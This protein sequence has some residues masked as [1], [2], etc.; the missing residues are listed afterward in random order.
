MK[1]HD[2]ARMAATCMVFMLHLQQAQQEACCSFRQR[3]A[4]DREH[5]NHVASRIVRSHRATEAYLAGV[6]SCAGIGTTAELPMLGAD[7]AGMGVCVQ[8][9]KSLG[10]LSSISTYDVV[11]RDAGTNLRPSRTLASNG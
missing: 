6:G 11:L 8:Q 10:A 7:V 1:A 3:S 4:L 9:S 2:T 5:A